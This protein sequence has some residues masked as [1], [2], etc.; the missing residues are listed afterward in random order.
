MRLIVDVDGTLTIDNPDASY[1][2][3]RPRRQVIQKLNELYDRGV[4]IVLYSARNM[5]T[6]KENVGRI[7]KHTLPVLLEWLTENGVKFHEIHM[8]KPWCGFEG[9]YVQQRSMRPARF[10]DLP[11]EEI[12]QEI[13]VNEPQG[14][15]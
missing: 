1:S 4:E 8:G 11:V 12:M 10:I 14:S 9:F 6:Y 2:E 13:A 7:N 3:R 15:R 5:R